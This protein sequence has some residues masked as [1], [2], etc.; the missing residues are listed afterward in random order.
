[1]A[2]PIKYGVLGA[3]GLHASFAKHLPSK[4]KE[5][6]YL[7]IDKRYPINE[8]MYL[9]ISHAA[10]FFQEKKVGFIVVRLNTLGGEINSTIKIA[11][12]FQK[13]DINYG[14]PLIAVVDKYAVASGALLGFAC[15]Y[16]AVTKEAIMGGQLP[17]KDSVFFTI[18][19]KWLPHLLNEYVM[20][21]NLYERNI[22]FAEAMADEKI[23]LVSRNGEVLRLN[24]PQEIASDDR[25]LTTDQDWLSLDASQMLSYGIADFEIED[26]DALWSELFKSSSLMQEPYLSRY[27]SA[28]MLHYQTW[29]VSVLMCL[30]YPA[31]SSLIFFLIIVLFYLQLK[32]CRPHFTGLIGSL[33]LGLGII[34]SV[35]IQA[36]SW[37]YGV[38]I[39]LGLVLIILDVG[40][41][42]GLGA[43][44]FWGM[45]LLLLGVFVMFLP[46]IQGLNF[47]E[48]D[49]YAFA[50]DYLLM[51]VLWI[52]S[53]FVL[54]IISCFMIKKRF[55]K[56]FPIPLKTLPNWQETSLGDVTYI[57]KTIERELPKEGSEG[58]A[59]S[60]LH[61]N[62]KVLIFDKVYDALTED[63]STILKKT[64]II[65][66]RQEVDKLIVRPR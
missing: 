48:F 42:A 63:G 56:F 59:H 26:G 30:A 34:T 2:S 16:I 40:F 55:G 50:K 18:P 43:R 8:S 66:V 1:M 65:V 6:G 15:R 31:L 58:I 62:G 33:L 29:I 61:P 11:G 64:Q 14:I 10:K 17:H 41:K 38:F 45:G 22:S 47:L 37:V 12:I 60:T 20:F 51:R 13:L 7:E 3:D 36:F 5:I 54:G 39:A 44:G 28:T 27:A 49:N 4:V 53:A 24:H 57:K 46:N 25:V 21:A 23:I 52:A 19:Q 35:S 32:L 9:Y